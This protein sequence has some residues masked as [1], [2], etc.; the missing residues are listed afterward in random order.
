MKR[1][2]VILAL[3]LALFVGSGILCRSA[4]IQHVDPPFW[5]VGMKNTTLQILLHGPKIAENDVTVKYGGVSVKDVVKTENPNYIF[6][7]LDISS[8]AKPG[9]M[10]ITLSGKD[11]KTVYSYELKER[12]KKPGA[13]GFT[14][15]DV[16]YLITRTASPTAI[17]RT[18]TW[19]AHVPTAA[20]PE[21]VTAVTSRACW[22]I[23]TISRT[24]A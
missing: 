16:L 6:L 20:A 17:R 2:P 4:E 5:W 23:W 9:K 19:K 12:S 14:T 7:Y 24:S 21:A 3:T 11:G 8:K 1:I 22:T 15:E 13:Q 18:T 10:D